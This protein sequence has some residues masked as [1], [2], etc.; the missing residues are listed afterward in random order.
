METLTDRIKRAGKL[1]AP[2]EVVA[3]VGQIDEREKA[4]ID[5]RTSAAPGVSFLQKAAKGMAELEIENRRQQRAY[6]EQAP[7]EIAAPA[8]EMVAN[9]GD[10][11]KVLDIYRKMTPEQRQE[12]LNLAPGIAQQLGDDR[13]GAVGRALGAVSRGISHGVSQPIMELTGLGG[14]PEEIDYIRQ[15]DAAAAQEFNPARPG[16]PWYERGPLQAAEMA[17]WMATVVGG[18]GLG[19][20]ALTQAAKPAAA[21]MAAKAGMGRATLKAAGKV[22]ELAGITAA[23]FPSQYAQEVDQLKEMGMEDNL[24]TRL[25]AGGTATVTGLIEGIVPNPFKAGP[26]PL[27]EGAIKAA[28][29]YLWNAAK[30]APGELT[31]EY[32]QGVT[33]GLGQ[34]VAQYLDANAE[35]KSIADAFKNGWDQAKEAA[36][37]MAFLLGAP[38]VGGAGL[39]AAQARLSQL[40]EVRAKGFVSLNDAKNLN[41]E[42]KN[43]KERLANADKQIEELTQQATIVPTVGTIPPPLQGQ[44]PAGPPRLPEPAGTAATP[45]TEPVLPPTAPV[46][47]ASQPAASQPG[48]SLEQPEVAE[49]SQPAWDVVQGTDGK[50][51]RQDPNAKTNIERIKTR[52]PVDPSEGVVLVTK[53]KFGKPISPET[54]QARQEFADKAKPGAE[55]ESKGYKGQSFKV[56]DDGTLLNSSGRKMG[57]VQTMANT[58]A[59]G[60]V[61]W[62]VDPERDQAEDELAGLLGEETPSTAGPSEGSGTKPTTVTPVVSPDAPAT[63]ET[64]MGET[65][66]ENQP[67]EARA[68]DHAKIP[69]FGVYKTTLGGKEKFAVKEFENKGFGDSLFDTKAEA[70]KHSEIAKRQSDDKIARQEK[71]KADEDA[72]VKKQQEYEGSFQGFLSDTPIVKGRQLSTLGKQRSY[73]GKVVTVK[74]L[75][76]RKVADGA[77]VNEAGQLESPD[78]AYLGSDKITKIGIDY[79]RHLIASK[80]VPADAAESKGTAAPPT[81]ATVD[82]IVPEGILN[83]S[84]E[85]SAAELERRKI[86][87]GS[88]A[89]RAFEAA[90]DD[91]GDGVRFI[92]GKGLPASMVEKSGKRINVMVKSYD[93][94]KGTFA[95]KGPDG[96][97]IQN[98]TP[99]DLNDPDDADIVR[100]IRNFKNSWGI[101]ATPVAKLSAEQQEALDFA[102]SRGQKLAFVDIAKSD[103]KAPIG[104]YQRDDKVVLISNALQGD[105]LWGMIGHEMAHSTGLDEILP[106]DSS[107]LKTMMDEYY[108]S[109]SPD[110]QKRLKT[111]KRDHMREGRAR[112]V[113]KFFEDKAFRDQLMQS[114]PTLWDKLR[115]AVLKFIGKWTPNDEAK[116]MLLDELRTAQKPEK[117]TGKKPA[118]ENLSKDKKSSVPEV[119]PDGQDGTFRVDSSRISLVEESAPIADKKPDEPVA[120]PL[121]EPVIPKFNR[122]T[123]DKGSTTRQFQAE[124]VEKAKAEIADLERKARAKRGEH[125]G[126]RSNATKKR[127]A[128][129]KDIEFLNR[130]INVVQG[131]IAADYAADTL[132]KLEDELESPRSYDHYLAG[133]KAIHKLKAGVAEDAARRG[134]MGREAARA[135]VSKEEKE[136]DRFDAE[137][138]GRAKEIAKSKGFT[139]G[140]AEQIALAASN[141]FTVFEDRSLADVV[142]VQAKRTRESRVSQ[143]IGEL[144]P[145]STYGR[146]SDLSAEQVEEFTKQYREASLDD[147]NWL[148]KRLVVDTAVKDAINESREASRKR[149]DDERKVKEAEKAKKEQEALTNA[150]ER[151]KKYYLDE[152]ISKALKKQKPKTKPVKLRQ[153]AVGGPVKIV[154]GKIV[155]GDF[156]G[157]LYLNGLIL[158]KTLEEGSNDFGLTHARSGLAFPFIAK[159]SA[160]QELIGLFDLLGVDF[161]VDTNEKGTLSAELVAR[162]KQINAAWDNEDYS[163]LS[164]QDYA[165]VQALAEVAKTDIDADLILTADDLGANGIPPG[166]GNV[167]TDNGLRIVKDLAIAVPEF[168]YDPVFTVKDGKL[169]YRD[170]YEFKLEPTAFNLHPS[171]LKEGQTVGINIEDLGI[172][173]STPQDVVAEMMKQ[174]GLPRVTKAKGG[175]VSVGY[176]GA[177]PTLL[178]QGNDD[179]EWTVAGGTPK[180]QEM[181]VAVLKKIRWRQPGQDGDPKTDIDVVPAVEKAQITDSGTVDPKEKQNRKASQSPDRIQQIQDTFQLNREQAIVADILADVTSPGEVEIALPGASMPGDSLTQ[182]SI[183]ADAIPK[184]VLDKMSRRLK[185]MGYDSRG[186]EDVRRAIKERNLLNFNEDWIAAYQFATGS[187]QAR[188]DKAITKEE[189]KNVNWERLR[190]LGTTTNPKEAG[191]IKPD[192]TFADFSGKRLGGSPGERAMDHREAGGTAGMQEIIAYGWIRMDENSG[193]LD[194]AKLPTAGQ[195]SAISRMADRHNGEIVVDLEDGLGEWSEGNEY[196]RAPMRRWSQEYP[197]GTKSRRIVNDIKKFFSGDTPNTLLQQQ[198]DQQGTI[199]AWTHFVSAS[200]AIIGAT[201]QADVSSFF[202]EWG[203][204]MRRFLFNRNATQEQRG[205]ITDEDIRTIEDFVGV[206]DGNWTGDDEEKFVD[207]MMS[208]W[209][210]GKAPTAQLETVFQKIAK[211]LSGVLSVIARKVELTDEV[212]AIFDKVHQRGQVSPKKMQSLADATTESPAEP[213]YGNTPLGKLFA[214]AKAAGGDTMLM[215]RMGDFYELYFE[216]AQKA[217]KMLGLTLTTRD[218][219]VD[220]PIPMTG[221]P[222]HQ[223]DGYLKKLKSAGIRIAVNE[224]PFP[225]KPPS[226]DKPKRRSKRLGLGDT[227]TDKKTGKE[228]TIDAVIHKNWGL[229]PVD[230]Y[231]VALVNL[232]DG[233]WVDEIGNR[234]VILEKMVMAGMS[235]DSTTE[236]EPPKQEVTEPV[237]SPSPVEADFMEM[238]NG[239]NAPGVSKTIRVTAGERTL[240]MEKGKNDGEWSIK[241]AEKYT[242]E[243]KGKT[244]VKTKGAILASGIIET[245]KAKEIAQR[246]IDGTFD[247]DADKRFVRE[248][249][250]NIGLT[251]AGLA[252][253]MKGA[254]GGRRDS[255]AKLLRENNLVTDG[256]LLLKVNDKDRDAILKGVGQ[257]DEGRPLTTVAKMMTDGRK[258]LSRSANAMKPIGYRGGYLD[259]R[260]VVLQSQ[261]GDAAIFDKSLHDT[262]LKKYPSAIP[263]FREDGEPISYAVDGDLVAI[264]MPMAMSK[265]D[266]K[267]KDLVD[268]KYDF[269]AEAAEAAK[270]PPPQSKTKLKKAAEKAN[271]E[272]AD[273]VDE[274][275]NTIKGKLGMNLP[276]NP[277]VIAAAAKV[278]AKA[279][280][281]GTLNFAELMERMVAKY[282]EKMANRMEAAL[283]QE[284]DRQVNAYP[285]A[286]E[287]GTPPE[288]PQP[289]P[290]LV[291]AE[292]IPLTSV[293]NAIV[294]ELRAQRG[295]DP[296]PEV[297]PQTVQQWLD[298][299]GNRI[300]SDPY[301]GN[302]LV[303]QLLSGEK[304][305]VDEMEGMVLQ[306][307]Y[308]AVNNLF[309]AADTKLTQAK[310]DGDPAAIAIAQDDARVIMRRLAAI[311]TALDKAGTAWGRAGVSRQIFLKQ[312]FSLASMVRRARVANGGNELSDEQVAKISEQ[313]K[314][315]EELQ[316]RI[317]ELEAKA[318]EQEQAKAIDEAIKK[319]IEETKK[320]PAEKPKSK[321]RLKAEERVA[322]AW[323]KFGDIAKGTLYSGVDLRFLPSAI[324]VIKAY[325]DLGVVTFREF[326]Y[327]AAK[328]MG[329]KEAK[330]AEPTFRAAW[331]QLAADGEITQPSLDITNVGQLT[332]FARQVQRSLVENG[333]TER[334]EIVDAVHDALREI[335]PEITRR[336][337]MDALS[338]YGQFSQLS[339][340]PID[341]II[342]DINGQLQQ[343]AKLEDMEKGIAPA[344]TGVER[345]SQSDEER[346]L[347]QLVN[348]A[349]RRGGFVVTDPE[350]QLKSAMAAAKTAVRNRI[351]D[352]TYEIQTG[353]RVVRNKTELIPDAELEQLRKDRDAL[354]QVHKDMFPPKGATQAQKIASANRALDAAIASLE[355]KLAAGDISPAPQAAPLSTPELDAKRAR[356]KALHDQR[357]ALRKT[358]EQT[359]VRALDRSIEA[360]EKELAAGDFTLKPKPVPLTSPEINARQAKLESLRATKKA[361]VAAANPNM[362]AER[363]SRAYE[364]HLRTQLAMYMDKIAQGDFAPKQKKQPRVLT[365]G[366]LDLKKQ[367]ADVKHDFFEALSKYHLDNLSPVGRAIDI[368]R[369]SA[370]LSRAIMTSIDLSAVLRQGGLGVYSHPVMA[371][372]A[373]AEMW[374]SIWSREKEFQS[375]EKLRSRPNA[376][377]YEESG[378]NITDS[379]GKLTRQEEAFMGRWARTG[380][381][382]AGKKVQAATKL[383]LEPVAASARAYVTFINNLRADLFDTMVE[384]LGQGGQVTKEEAKVIAS[385]INVAT[386]RSDFKKFNDWAATMNAVFFAPRYVASRFQYLAMPF[387]V[388]GSSKNSGRVKMLIAKE[389]ARTFTGAAVFIGSLTALA[390]LA[391]MADDDEEE[392]P[393]LAINPLAGDMLSADFGKVRIDDTRIDPL[394]GLAQVIVFSSRMLSFHTKSI[395]TGKIKPFYEGGPYETTHGSELWRFTRTKF[396]PVPG[397]VATVFS[398]MKNVVGDDVTPAELVGGL[399][400]PISVGEVWSTMRHRGI[401]KGLALNVLNFMGASV[402]TYGPKTAYLDATPEERAK[403]VN[404]Y[405]KYMNWE[406]DLP[407]FSQYL[408][409][410]DLKRV[411]ARQD[412]RRGDL[413]YEAM[414]KVLPKHEYKT[415]VHYEEAAERHK[416]VSEEFDNFRKQFAPTYGDALRYLTHYFD[417]EGGVKVQGA[418]KLKPSFIERREKLAAH[419]QSQ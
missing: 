51:Y 235:V 209:M 219:S 29:Q 354:R 146:Q 203:H 173:R 324:E 121:P 78:G 54:L 378:L 365:Q 382:F 251:N 411:Q 14:T 418:R 364:A 183:D 81:T 340:D 149:D 363:A 198:R 153:E 359:K 204:P 174:A 72:A 176:V 132:A 114:N 193:S 61:S 384:N 44:P 47:P 166:L 337:T 321:V 237:A 80:S 323:K 20:A 225:V 152:R 104:S 65:A 140:D 108:Q 343:L 192:G 238:S 208:Y 113:Q 287:D 124:R 77:I 79:A 291:P 22:G 245:K 234:K 194:I 27:A 39:S 2:T 109:A 169:L 295:E 317:A 400:V 360:L 195:L 385:Y 181:A 315:I 30:Q 299:A 37:P 293:K 230:K 56:L 399:F 398:G 261:D 311:E 43:R 26:V 334:E 393:S 165:T 139:S 40:Q 184:A 415:E 6:A 126:L 136:A 224:A 370:H 62:K 187:E 336:Q 376:Q 118:Q 419:Y 23:A 249:A 156:N 301:A 55:F 122:T 53:D 277:E 243:V 377:L 71:A 87:P 206:E 68:D 226:D 285:V 305:S 379:E 45:P 106:A 102:T 278:V 259:A 241:E 346:R 46:D 367:L 94:E 150:R 189:L 107:E 143:E 4:I 159:K 70:T 267:L 105:K 252:E 148:A 167:M 413:V 348:E 19:R 412:E 21:M 162:A 345:R 325:A 186:A 262:I 307:H 98:I 227:F 42:G 52:Q 35:D 191:Y 404:K 15:L 297:T 49:P 199:Q 222:Y 180:V 117:R 361:L 96:G 218:K 190:E 215:F 212:R 313:A 155:D 333:V 302:T 144:K 8:R 228:F 368:I 387:Y 171:E 160:M 312:D 137:L 13:G 266:S 223:L 304:T 236:R 211:W 120:E 60:D 403:Q 296:M 92:P 93:Q 406:S 414:G 358:D 327:S 242:G 3:G 115:E 232:N 91:P 263:Y 220:N 31:E 269:E 158:H 59:P 207:A 260:T 103:K 197:E 374:R 57:D 131:E 383:A 356:L 303:E 76:E 41:I 38:A 275:G 221:F 308:R 134:E 82:A 380:V 320:P 331:D 273:A 202:H 280:K 402:N 48:A 253:A 216:D 274:L 110:V 271:K 254:L 178:E 161:N 316:K 10:R 101:E 335:L 341:Q 213:K 16:D 239:V 347:T 309:E 69:M 28:R 129:R 298:A 168:T 75:I 284:W 63:P 205:D 217:A 89:A 33:S 352:M 147:K 283:Q 86:K 7:P 130:R 371:R 392:K 201:D 145:E 268:G 255:F 270:F 409:P 294:D 90:T 264:V 125:D 396:A 5:R 344:K 282:G 18:A 357:N 67:S 111:S 389:Y 289:H 133:M 163:M 229:A 73:Q 100:A 286:D 330:A 17:P 386:G 188:K 395:A 310:A 375:M 342:R 154:D 246:I 351:A 265:P 355:A 408:P 314:Q 231:D 366:E 210:E 128:V 332:R 172:K 196:Y 272:L 112:M 95:V 276:L 372:K 349:K 248:D 1:A 407:A 416:K 240:V 306:Y 214:E 85:S 12:A 390:Y 290:E 353:S 391:A 394:A 123:F 175:G 151:A 97:W 64:S 83:E 319:D 185:S 74:E 329:A 417:D 58:V 34:H 138:Q 164:E 141:W 233:G 257:T 142:E 279:I 405:I 247:K 362:A 135:E 127:A 328:N 84:N 281:A 177:K 116:R 99:G 300:A 36:L 338:S 50:L 256:R 250:Q 88:V 369:E 373:A 119:Q 350:T 258:A 288:T 66:G 381:D 322:A 179:N 410:E 326:M 9:L 11:T 24:T 200:K 32:L 244:P 157:E 170:G 401:P 182:S 339:K 397:A 318:A 25:L 292:S 388:L